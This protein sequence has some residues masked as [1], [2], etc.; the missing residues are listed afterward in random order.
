MSEWEDTTSYSRDERGKIE[1]RCWELSMTGLCICVH[2]HIGF[3]GEWLLSCRELDIYRC[4]WR[5]T[6]AVPECKLPRGEDAA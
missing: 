2:R 3:P 1:P 5:S 4:D 6:S